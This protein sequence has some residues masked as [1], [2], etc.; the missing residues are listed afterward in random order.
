[1]LL[2]LGYL[3]YNWI[4]IP[5][6]VRCRSAFKL[7]EIDQK[8]NIIKPGYTVIDCGAAPGS[9]SQLAVQQSNADGSKPDKPKGMVIG[10]DLLQIYPI[11]V[12]IRNNQF[13]FNS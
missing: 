3:S 5:I 9:W 11:T 6:Y 10:I 12:G 7:L 4:I 8:Y 1:M 13:F 2:G